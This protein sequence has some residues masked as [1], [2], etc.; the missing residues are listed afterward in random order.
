MIDLLKEGV[1]SSMIAKLMLAQA[2][3]GPFHEDEQ[4]EITEF[5]IDVDKIYIT[6]RGVRH[7]LQTVEKLD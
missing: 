2:K 7:V 1:A 6:N 5:K 4:Y 3:I